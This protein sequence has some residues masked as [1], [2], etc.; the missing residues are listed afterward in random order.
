MV[1][2]VKVGKK[3]DCWMLI[4]FIWKTKNHKLNLILKWI[5]SMVFKIFL[6]IRFAW[7]NA[8][9]CL[10]GD[11]S[12]VMSDYSQQELF[13]FFIRDQFVIFFSKQ[14]LFMQYHWPPVRMYA[15]NLRDIAVFYYVLNLKQ[16][17]EYLCFVSNKIVQVFSIKN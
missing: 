7:C 15:W 16:F 1:S 2:F 17:K 9:F 14:F 10:L 11:A 6:L 12:S 3:Y 13:L 4:T 5:A 8:F